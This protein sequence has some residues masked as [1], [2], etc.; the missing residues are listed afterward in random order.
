MV[1]FDPK[2][3]KRDDNNSTSEIEYEDLN[4]ILPSMLLLRAF[5]LAWLETARV[6][7]EGL[8]MVA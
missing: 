6:E 7:Y 1:W 5:K 8:I 2:V 4:F 3:V